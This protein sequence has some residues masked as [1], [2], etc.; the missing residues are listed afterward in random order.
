VRWVSCLPVQ[1][2]VSDAGSA[3]PAGHA[4]SAREHGPPRH[5]HWRPCGFWQKGLSNSLCRQARAPR[6]PARQRSWARPGTGLEH[7]GLSDALGMQA[8]APQW[9]AR[10]RSWARPGTGAS[11]AARCRGPATRPARRPAPLRTAPAPAACRTCALRV[12][13]ASCRSK[14]RR[15]A[16]PVTG[17]WLC[18]G[19]QG[20]SQ[21]RMKL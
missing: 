18:Q 8:R 2:S 5:G 10:R 14:A 11:A 21:P 20:Y 6:W 1:R 12:S 19:C 3:C 9:P 7:M 4:C 17:A 13:L 16:C 15:H